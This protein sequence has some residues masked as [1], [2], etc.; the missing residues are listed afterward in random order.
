MTSRL[1]YNPDTIM[2]RSSSP[3]GK[4]DAP[5]N[6][7]PAFKR[8]YDEIRWSPKEQTAN[9]SPRPRRYKKTYGPQRR[10]S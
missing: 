9:G 10:K 3:A 2:N 4:G 1:D 5:R 7:G 8:N 6:V